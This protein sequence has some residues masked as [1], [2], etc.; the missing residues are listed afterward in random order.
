MY[1]DATTYDTS[2]SS[3]YNAAQTV[4]QHILYMLR[5]QVIPHI[6]HKKNFEY[7]VRKVSAYKSAKLTIEA[8][9]KLDVCVSLSLESCSGATP[10]FIFITGGYCVIRAGPPNISHP[11]S[12]RSLFFCLNKGTKK[13][14]L[15]ESENWKEYKNALKVTKVIKR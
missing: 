15:Q 5:L 9:V 12:I 8:Q 6:N 1:L 14:V 10:A 3:P 7:K 11:S 4:C 13:G 2:Y